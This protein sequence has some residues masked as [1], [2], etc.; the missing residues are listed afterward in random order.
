LK[1]RREL[2]TSLSLPLLL[3]T[4]AEIER[5]FD[6]IKETSICTRKWHLARR[7]E[8]KRKKKK[9]RRRKRKRKK[10]KRKK[11]KR[12]GRESKGLLRLQ[13]VDFH[14]LVYLFPFRIDP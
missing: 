12:G 9:R 14:L 10:R 11:R 7:L 5:I 1:L 13:F 2:R 3:H 4:N 8:E 6:F